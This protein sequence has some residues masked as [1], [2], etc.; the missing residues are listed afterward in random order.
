L[1]ELDV[2]GVG[3]EMSP[4]EASLLMNKVLKNFYANH[5]AIYLS[6]P[7]SQSLGP[8]LHSSRTL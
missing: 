4:I 3:F 6:L 5:L 1:K 7:N 2:E 8:L